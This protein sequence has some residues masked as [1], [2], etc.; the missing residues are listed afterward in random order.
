MQKYLII[1]VIMALI[2]CNNEGNQPNQKENSQD[3]YQK[4]LDKMNIEASETKLHEVKVLES[5]ISGSY[6]YALLEEDGKEFWAAISAREL[7]IGATYYYEGGMEMTNFESKSL[8]KV[9]PSIWFI[10]VF[11]DSKPQVE[12]K[13][14]GGDHSKAKDMHTAVQVEKAEGGYSLAEVFAQKTSLKGQEIMV[15]GQVVKINEMIMNTNWVHI[16]DGTEYNG[17][18]DL[19]ITTSEAINFK[20]GDVVTFKGKLILNKDFGH[21]YKYDFLL[22]EAVQQ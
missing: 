17:I 19:T 5:S 20:I 15:K 8:G 22:E 10:D 13:T 14:I 21:G 6:T 4:A 18:Y 12:E 3:S 11:H 2:S 7:E 9:F 1:F 16:Q